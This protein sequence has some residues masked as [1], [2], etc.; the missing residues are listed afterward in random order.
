[1]PTGNLVRSH[2][3]AETPAQDPPHQSAEERDRLILEHLPLVRL[4]AHKVHDRLPEA[5]R[6]SRSL[7]QLVSAGIAGLIS[8]VDRFDKAGNIQLEKYADYRI[9]GAIMDSLRSWPAPAEQLAAGQSFER[10]RREIPE[11][12]WAHALKTFGSASLATDW[13]LTECGALGNRAPIE[14]MNDDGGGREIDR[15]LGCI[16]YGM[17]A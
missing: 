16:D 9:R 7:D 12:V 2:R 3:R 11:F 17:I 1:M 10:M 5:I 8:A 14:T 15:I 6:K 4:I 13:F